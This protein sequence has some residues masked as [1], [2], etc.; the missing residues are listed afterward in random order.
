MS[1]PVYVVVDRDGDPVVGNTT[2]CIADARWA[3]AA[4]VAGASWLP[5]GSH[6]ARYEP[7][8]AV[9]QVR[10][11]AQTAIEQTRGAL[12]SADWQ[13]PTHTELTVDAIETALRDLESAIVVAEAAR[14]VPS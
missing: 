14:Q 5:K 7:S 4:E 8:R 10:L 12:E 13:S 2:R 6:V 3:Y 11:A 1:A 9:D